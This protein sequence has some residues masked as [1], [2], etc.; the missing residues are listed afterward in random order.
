[1]SEFE[2]R[3]SQDSLRRLYGS[4]YGLRF[5]RAYWVAFGIAAV[6]MAAM[7][8]Q[9]SAPWYLVAPCVAA[10]MT[11]LLLSQM[12]ASA[13]R[14]ALSYL[15]Q[16]GAAGLR[17]RVDDEG[18]TET[19]SLG[20]TQMRWRAFAGTRELEGHLLLERAPREAMMFVA[21]PLDQ[22]PAGLRERLE[23]AV[24]A[25]QAAHAG[26]GTMG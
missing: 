26:T 24:R 7:M 17:Y 12:R 14:L 9:R 8:L 21:L 18:L 23:G 20:T 11:Q 4:A 15:D 3:H 1:M 5:R 22:L 13:I 6:L 25:A 10:L 16:F 2:V 19:S